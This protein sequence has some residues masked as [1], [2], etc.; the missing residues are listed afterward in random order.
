MKLFYRIFGSGPALMIL[1]GLY[2]S[3]DNWVTIARRISEKYT[4]ILPDLRNHGQSPH[5][6]QHTYD[7]M[8]DDIHELAGE[9]R[10][11]RFI[12]AGHSMGGRVAMK[13]AI[14][15]P[16]MINS[17]V[18]ADISPYGPATSESVFYSQHKK[19]LETI[20][21]VDPKKYAAR[22]DIEELL[23]SGISSEK[24]RGF[25]MKNLG[26]NDQG[27]FE[28]K[29]NASSL[30]ENLW[31]ITS[32]IAD[33]KETGDPVTGFSV[34]FLKGENSEYINPE[35]FGK[36]MRLFPAA[37]FITIKNAGHWLHADSP[38]EIEKILLGLD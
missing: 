26:R 31:E 37:E 13:F 23:C 20:L 32:G 4:V 17:L 25:I 14:R 28:W 18:V 16:E 21:S 33:E 29:L 22:K 2:G 24:I 30:L 8:A 1:H 9:L 38:D 5:S 36:I 12:L 27:A 6:E 34:T 7:L 10:L 15:W 11:D 3:S 35:D 19:I